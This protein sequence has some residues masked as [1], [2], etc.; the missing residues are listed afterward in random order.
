MKRVLAAM[1][2]LAVPG[3]FFLNSWE[4]YRYNVLSD[5]IAE[6]EKQQ[7]TLLEANRD[8]IGQIAFESSPDRIAEKA[9]GLGLVQLDPATMTRQQAVRTD[10]KGAT[11]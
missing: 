9:A 4:G 2:C 3:L 10:G 1:I 6:L 7:K 5:R 8:A 11:R